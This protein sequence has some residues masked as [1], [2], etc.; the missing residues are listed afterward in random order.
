MI[1]SMM[2]FR[3]QLDTEG[4]EVLRGDIGSGPEAELRLVLLGKTGSGK[5]S[6]GNSLLGLEAFTV[7]RGMCSGTDRCQFALT[8]WR[9]IGLQVTDT[10]G[11]CDTHRSEVEVL[12]EVGKSLVVASPGPHVILMVLRCDRRF[13]QEEYDAYLSLKGLFGAD[14]CQ[15]MIVVF[16]GLDCLGATQEERDLRLH[17][18]VASCPPLLRNVIEDAR[19][20][21]I[22]VNN[23]APQAEITERVDTLLQHIQVC[24]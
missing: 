20:R 16:V 17:Q 14:I 8:S 3:S 9:G 2:E 13:T 7:A 1:R 18:E 5:S 15:H 10:P 22:G 21:Y 23:M 24:C 4:Q 6:L 19:G 12:R 11:V